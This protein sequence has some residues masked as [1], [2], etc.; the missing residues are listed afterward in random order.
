M[1]KLR[2]SARFTRQFGGTVE[3]EQLARSSD[4]VTDGVAVQAQGLGRLL[5]LAPVAQIRDQG[6]SDLWTGGGQKGIDGAAQACD[7]AGAWEDNLARRRIERLQR[8]GAGGPGRLHRDEV[9]DGSDDRGVH[10]AELPLEF[11]RP[12]VVVGKNEPRGGSIDSD[13]Q[14]VRAP[15]LDRLR[16][17]LAVAAADH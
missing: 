10:Q 17:G 4:S 5:P 3:P 8:P 11:P 15:P 14:G 2:E 1:S 12:A 6:L 7:T 16:K 9:R 13:G